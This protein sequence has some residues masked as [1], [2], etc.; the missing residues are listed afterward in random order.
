ME[1]K[2]AD[3]KGFCFGVRR[4]FELAE[5]A[6]KENSSLESLGAI[7][8]NR[9]VVDYFQERG[10]RII[11]NL[12]E[13]K[14]DTLLIPSHGVGQKI[15]AQINSLNL[16]LID[17]TCPIVRNAQQVAHQLQVEGFQVLVYGDASHTE[18]KE[19]TVHPGDFF[20]IPVGA[21]VTWTVGSAK[22]YRF[23]WLTLP[24]IP[25]PTGTKA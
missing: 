18:V 5:T 2:L 4:A 22:P 11:K 17:A 10:I 6:V 12:D 19:I 3:E 14:G 15:M 9:Q 20:I 1:I 21:R 24:G 23:L 25:R 16:H 8:H 7:V 13:M